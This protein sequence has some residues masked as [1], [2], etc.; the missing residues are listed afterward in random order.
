N[1]FLAIQLLVQRFIASRHEAVTET[2]EIPGADINNEDKTVF[3]RVLSV[4][5][6]VEPY[7]SSD[8]IDL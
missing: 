2:I 8:G 5:F 1:G 6:P 4:P 7:W 3:K